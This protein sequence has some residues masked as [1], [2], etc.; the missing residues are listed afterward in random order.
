MTA[1]MPALSIRQPWAWLIVNGFKDVENREWH[2]PF[3][4]RMLVHAGKQMTRPECE[5]VAG[6][7]ATQGLLPPTFPPYESL[8]THC[9]GIVGQARITDCVEQLDSPWF[10]G[11]YGF[12][13]ADAQPAPFWPVNGKLGFFDVKVNTA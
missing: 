6:Q 11:P 3:R 10:V 13:L 9:G 5:R 7:L 1:R 2:T 4:G 8:R 12:V